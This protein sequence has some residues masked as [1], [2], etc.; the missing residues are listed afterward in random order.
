[1]KQQPMKQGL[2]RTPGILCPTLSEKWVDSLTFPAN[3]Y[4]EDAGDG[5]YSLSFLFEKTYIEHLTI[6]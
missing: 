6:C 4:R 5:A 3:Q 1:M 2:T